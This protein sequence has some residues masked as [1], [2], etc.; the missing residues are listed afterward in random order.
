MQGADNLNNASN[1]LTEVVLENNL[2]TRAASG[3]HLK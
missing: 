1:G 2:S 3:I